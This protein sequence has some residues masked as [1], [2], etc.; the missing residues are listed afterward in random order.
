MN[1][2]AVI[3][4]FLVGGVGF[5]SSVLDEPKNPPLSR[6]GAPGELTCQTSDCHKGGSFVGTVNITGMPD[7]VLAG[8][9]YS[10]VLTQTSNA[11]RA[12]FELTAIDGSSKKAGNLTNG[13]GTS[14]AS[15]NN[16][17]YIRQSLPKNLSNGSVSWSF[18]WTAPTSITSSDSIKF[19]FVSLASDNSGKETGDNVLLGNKKVVLIPNTSIEDNQ[20]EEW[21]NIYSNHNNLIVDSE[22]LIKSVMV[23]D[24]TGRLLKNIVINQEFNQQVTFGLEAGIYIIK[25]ETKSG[26][27]HAT[28]IAIK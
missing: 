11:A 10:I 25:V 15:Q 24:L 17:E 9:K 14:I 6:T 4:A 1:K 21:I 13:T 19:Y 2:L 3:I 5:M 27:L 26:K 12:G 22:D 16:K 20:I 18:S 8:V 7:T 23:N 28:K